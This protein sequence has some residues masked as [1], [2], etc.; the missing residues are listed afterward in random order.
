M[1]QARAAIVKQ[2]NET[3]RNSNLPCMWLPQDVHRRELDISY[4]FSYGSVY[5]LEEHPH[6]AVGT[7]LR[8]S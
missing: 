3:I 1:C 4:N 7:K 5:Q 8:K 6:C 2:H